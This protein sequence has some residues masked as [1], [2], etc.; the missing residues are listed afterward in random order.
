MAS[1]TSSPLVSAA[2]PAPCTAWNTP[3]STFVLTFPM[4]ATSS[5]FPTANPIRQPVMLYVLDREWNSMHLFFAPGS[6]RMLIGLF[7]S[8]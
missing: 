5:G 8:K 2:I 7:P 3:L 6:S 4:P 1:V